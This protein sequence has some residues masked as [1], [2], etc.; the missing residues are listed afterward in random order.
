MQ[1]KTRDA[2]APVQ[3][4]GS[5]LIRTRAGWHWRTEIACLADQPRSHTT[6]A[7]ISNPHSW[8]W[9]A[10]ALHGGARSVRPVGS[11]DLAGARNYTDRCEGLTPPSTARA[12]RYLIVKLPSVA[13]FAR[14]GACVR[15][16]GMRNRRPELG[17]GLLFGRTARA[18]WARC[19][20]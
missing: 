2:W 9:P 19:I 13:A 18:I 5:G 10:A 14:S 11:D 15:P 16:N 1:S 4:S 7:G 12:H 20:R 8:L 3:G 17:I 6:R